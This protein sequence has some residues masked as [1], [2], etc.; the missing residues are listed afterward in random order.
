ML[1]DLQA[2]ESHEIGMNLT[3]LVKFVTYCWNIGVAEDTNAKVI[4]SID[5][6]HSRSIN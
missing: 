1:N 6:T 2:K 5:A 3:V 4:Y